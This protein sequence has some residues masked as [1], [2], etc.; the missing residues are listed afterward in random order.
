MHVRYVQL[1][2]ELQKNSKQWKS[3]GYN[4]ENI[5]SSMD[6][7][8]SLQST[9]LLNTY[10]L[11]DHTFFPPGTYMTKNAS[12]MLTEFNVLGGK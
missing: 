7:E 1:T 4:S 8:I 2:L 12:N 3:T 11:K 5:P 10:S 9:E 6:F